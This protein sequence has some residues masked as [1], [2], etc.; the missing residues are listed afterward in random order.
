M[1]LFDLEGL[2]SKLGQVNK[3][4][5][6]DGFW[7]DQGKAQKLLKEKKSLENTIAGYEK[8]VSVL[9]DIEV[10]IEMAEDSERSGDAEG[11]SEMAAKPHRHMKNIKKQRRN[12]G[13]EHCSMVNT[14]RAMLYFRCMLVRAV[15]MLW[16]GRRCFCVCIHAGPKREGILLEC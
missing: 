7:N 9:D 13:S 5:E 16:T 12:C 1:T 2:K 4:T 6:E 3:E 15:L 11:A 14:M 8:L 10:M